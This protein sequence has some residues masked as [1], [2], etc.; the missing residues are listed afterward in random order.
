MFFFFYFLIQ[1]E[2][3]L[4][5]FLL[6]LQLREK[7]RYTVLFLVPIF[8]YWQQILNLLCRSSFSVEYGEIWT[9]K[10]LCIQTLLAQWFLVLS[11][12]NYTSNWCKILNWNILIFTYFGGYI[13]MCIHLHM[14]K[15]IYLSVYIFLNIRM[16]LNLKVWIWC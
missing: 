15:N 7:L 3:W 9:T 12:R 6:L 10:K 13:W 14:H 1:H 2:L 8:L 5:Y 11:K 4:M 16:Y